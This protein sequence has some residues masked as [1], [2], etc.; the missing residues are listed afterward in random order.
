MVVAG[1]DVEYGTRV[2]GKD[3]RARQVWQDMDTSLIALSRLRAKISVRQLFGLEGGGK[4]EFD[5]N[6]SDE[7]HQHLAW[8]HN[9]LQVSCWD[10]A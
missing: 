9:T 3:L 8:D 6:H 10:L 5:V 4:I 2:L 7:A 1:S